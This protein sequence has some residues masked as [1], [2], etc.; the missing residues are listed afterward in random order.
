MTPDKRKSIDNGIWLC[1]S[2]AKLIDSDIQKYDVLTLG[3][4]KYDAEKEQNLVYGG[5]NEGDESVLPDSTDQILAKFPTLKHC[6]VR[7]H[8]DD[9][10]E[11]VAGIDWISPK[12]T[13]FRINLKNGQNYI[14]T[15]KGKDFEAERPAFTTQVAL[16]SFSSK[17]KCI[18]YKKQM[19]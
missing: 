12:P 6:L 11:F 1:D 13:G 2:C 3:K 8:T 17:E 10:P 14:L 15:W 9:Y 4:W 18:T 5:V 19:R 16:I 7:L